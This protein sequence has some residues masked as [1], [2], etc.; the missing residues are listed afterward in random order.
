MFPF[1]CS[2]MQFFFLYQRYTMQGHSRGC[3]YGALEVAAILDHWPTALPKNCANGV[4]WNNHRMWSL[5]S[6]WSMQ[7][8]HLTTHSWFYDVSKWRS[9]FCS[10]VVVIQTKIWSSGFYLFCC[11]LMLLYQMD[12][13]EDCDSSFLPTFTRE[14]CQEHQLCAASLCDCNE[15]Q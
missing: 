10:V 11:A 3:N 6:S 12:P 8:L 9:R 2:S 7:L 13:L 14:W 5:W 4:N 1:W 15:D